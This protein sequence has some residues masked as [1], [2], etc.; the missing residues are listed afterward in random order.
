MPCSQCE[1]R[2][3]TSAGTPCPACTGQNAAAAPAAPAAPVTT[4]TPTPAPPPGVVG[5]GVLRSPVG[6]GRAAMILLLLVA[7]ADVASITATFNMRRLM[8]GVLDGGFVDDG[9][10]A[11]SERD[12]DFA[13]AM[14]AVTSF[15]GMALVLATMVVFIIW[16]HRVR[17]NAG[18]FAT[19]WFTNGTG[20]AIG[21]WFIPIGNLWIPRR[22]AVETWTASRADHLAHSRQEPITLVNAWWTAWLI[23]ICLGRVA[24]RLYDRAETPG[25]IVSAANFLVAADVTNIVAAVLAILFVR[26]LTHMQHTKALA[27]SQAPRTV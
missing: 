26:R 19:D 11:V 16:F 25:E 1:H 27:L 24:G 14:M 9:F 22:V 3:T 2:S 18:V 21:S 13:D 8:A 17:C 23:T 12:A 7:V 15:A 20:M 6:L 10:V 5:S 4:L